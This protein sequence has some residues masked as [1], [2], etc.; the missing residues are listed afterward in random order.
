MG[1]VSGRLHPENARVP[2]KVNSIVFSDYVS[3]HLHSWIDLIFGKDQD[4]MEKFNVFQTLAYV[5][6]MHP[7]R[8]ALENLSA[9][10][11]QIYYFGQNPYALFNREHPKKK[12]KLNSVSSKNINLYTSLD[13]SLKESTTTLGTSVNQIWEE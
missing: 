6:N 4:S 10:I 8:I 1:L 2:G 12:A 3:S 7:D 5:E 13:L 9:I 11:S